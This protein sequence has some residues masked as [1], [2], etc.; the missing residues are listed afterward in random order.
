MNR[1]VSYINDPS[2]SAS[3]RSAN[4]KNLAGTVNEVKDEVVRFAETRVAM[5]QSEMKEKLR[6]YRAKAP[7]FLVGGLFAVTAFL[8][9]TAALISVIAT[10]FAGSIYAVFLASLIV[11]VVYGIVGSVA[12]SM[13]FK[14]VSGQTLVPERTIK[15]LKDDKAW[16]EKETRIAQ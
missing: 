5:L 8:A 16:L 2:G 7:A 15:V 1:T 12:L 4:G 3:E 14:G 9:F 13:A 6:A 10:L 11:A